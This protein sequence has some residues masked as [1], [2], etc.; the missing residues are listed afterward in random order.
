MKNELGFKLPDNVVES[1]PGQY[2]LFSWMEY[3]LNIP[4]PIFIITTKKAN[5]KSNACPCSWG[6]FSGKG[7]GY[8][9]LFSLSQNSHT[10]SNIKRDQEWCINL[11]TV[12]LKDKFFKTIEVNHEDNDEIVDAGLTVESSK[13]ISSPRIKESPIS[14]ECKFEWEKELFAGSP[15]KIICG[16]V[17]HLAAD[18]KAFNIDH[19]QRIEDMGI[20]YNIR[21]HLNPLTGEKSMNNAIGILNSSIVKY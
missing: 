4:Y 10:Y 18:D 6:Y 11:P 3:V 14:L 19:K 7:S 2:T 20:M 1:W 5:G 12:Q 21:A 16:K 13:V 8:Y 15:E 9:S 17:V